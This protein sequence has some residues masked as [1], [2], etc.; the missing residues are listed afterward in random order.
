M[1]VRRDAS[2]LF[3][4]LS[5]FAIC[6]LLQCL[7]GFLVHALNTLLP[8]PSHRR[9]RLLLAAPPLAVIIVTAISLF[10]ARTHLFGRALA[11]VFAGLNLPLRAAHLLTTPPRASKPLPIPPVALAAL[12]CTLPACP[13]VPSVECATRRRPPPTATDPRANALVGVWRLA[14]FSI[15]AATLPLGVL[16]QTPVLLLGLTVLLSAASTLSSAVFGLVTGIPGTA[17]YSWPWLSPSLASFWAWR[18]NSPIADALRAGVY[19]PLVVYAGVPEVQAVLATFAA[20]GAGH[21]LMLYV[22]GGDAAGCWRWQAFFTVQWIGVVGERILGFPPVAR[23]AAA[24]VFFFVTCHYWFIRPF[25][26]CAGFDQVML[27]L[28]SGA[29]LAKNAAAMLWLTVRR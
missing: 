17:P 23:R 19:D 25:V 12:L 27:E 2:Y 13:L 7:G 10:D 6:A 11:A 26:E 1:A 4:L 15:V 3:E 24:L 9:T 14:A 21:V 28:G 22:I 18:W 29:R 16:A 8:T 20:S 5:R